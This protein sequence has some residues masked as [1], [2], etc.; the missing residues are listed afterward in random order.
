M[1][2]ICLVREDPCLSPPHH[3]SVEKCHAPCRQVGVWKQGATVPPP[4]YCTEYDG[5]TKE[6][7]IQISWLQ[8]HG[9]QRSL[10][11]R[12]LTGLSCKVTSALP[13]EI[14]FRPNFLDGT[15]EYYSNGCSMR[16]VDRASLVLIRKVQFTPHPYRLRILLTVRRYFL[17]PQIGSVKPWENALISDTLPFGPQWVNHK[18]WK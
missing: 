17:A 12:A 2:G 16:Q 4:Q 5:I 6:P 3:S 9:V 18:P 14:H 13:P 15:E 10:D 11:L 8:R 7:S 1:E